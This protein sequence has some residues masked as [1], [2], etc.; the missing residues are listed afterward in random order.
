MLRLFFA[1]TLVSFSICTYGADLTFRGKSYSAEIQEAATMPN[2]SNGTFLKYKIVLHI[3]K[4]G[5]YTRTTEHSFLLLKKGHWSDGNTVF[6]YDPTRTQIRVL[7][8]SSTFENQVTKIGPE[9]IQDKSIY[10]GLDKPHSNEITVVFP[11]QK[12]GSVRNIKIEEKWVRP[13]RANFFS[14]SFRLAE[15]VLFKEYEISL[16]SE[17]PLSIQLEDQEKY[18]SLVKSVAGSL[19]KISI[20]LGREYYLQDSDALDTAEHRYV[21]KGFI[22][23]N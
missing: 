11:E 23:S 22:S 8:A 2:K 21:P 10:Q 19:K 3:N 7:E 20:K 16:D 9:M 18:L 4:D 15:G 12:I 17:L 1:L 6:N 14:F 5:S 13:L